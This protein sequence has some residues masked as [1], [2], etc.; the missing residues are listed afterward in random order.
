MPRANVFCPSNS[1]LAVGKCRRPLINCNQ[2]KH[3]CVALPWRADCVYSSVTA[4]SDRSRNKRGAKDDK[5]FRV[6]PT[7]TLEQANSASRTSQRGSHRSE[8]GVEGIGGGDDAY[9]RAHK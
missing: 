1:A 5:V 6:A 2:T 9:A 3:L 4:G 7:E 8:C